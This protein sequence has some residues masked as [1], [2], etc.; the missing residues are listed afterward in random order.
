MSRQKN[1]VHQQLK[2]IFIKVFQTK[3]LEVKP[4]VFQR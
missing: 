3:N 4:E 1:V 2:D